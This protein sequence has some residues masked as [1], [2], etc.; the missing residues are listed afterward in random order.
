MSEVAEHGIVLQQVRKHFGIG[1]IIDGYKVDV[2]IT[3]RG[4]KNISS[5]TTKSVDTN[6]HRHR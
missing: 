5:D 4:A 2:W 3:E 1:Q 6:L